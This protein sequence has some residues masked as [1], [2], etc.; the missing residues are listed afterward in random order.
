MSTGACTGLRRLV[1]GHALQAQAP[2]FPTPEPRA[3]LP[4]ILG[5][6]QSRR[7]SVLT[8]ARVERD[9]FGANPTSSLQA[10]HVLWISNF[11]AS[12]H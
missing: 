1:L 3:N 4:A 11:K 9:P 2:S 5:L 12:G 10:R 7:I 6:E 8:L